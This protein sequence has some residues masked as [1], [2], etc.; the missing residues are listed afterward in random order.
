MTGTTDGSDS[1]GYR[2]VSPFVRLLGTHGRVQVLDVFL[3]Q[4]YSELSVSEIADLANISPST[5]HRNI[6]E[7]RELGI[8]EVAGSKGN[9]TYYQLNTDNPVAQVIGEA[10]RELLEYQ[11][12]VLENTKPTNFDY[13]EY[14]VQRA[15]RHDDRSTAQDYKIDKVL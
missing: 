6:N 9:T 15:K 12:E 2:D 1:H 7:I 14:A 3:R 13:Q 11:A 4:P 5:F 8:V 10:H